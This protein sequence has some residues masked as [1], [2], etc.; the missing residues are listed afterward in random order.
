MNIAWEKSGEKNRQNLCSHGVLQILLFI[1][2]FIHSL[3]I[4][5]IFR[6]EVLLCQPGWNVTGQA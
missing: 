1:Y 4:I 3:I 6:D 2:L 5:V